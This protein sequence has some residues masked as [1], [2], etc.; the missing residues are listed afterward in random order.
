M[1]LLF[2]KR[3][4]ANP[5]RVGY[6]VP[7]SPALTRKVAKRIDFT[8]PRVVVELGPGE[9]CHTRQIVKRMNPESKLLLFEL[10]PEFAGHLR[11]QFAHDPRVTVLHT[12]AIHLPQTLRELG[13]ERCD[14]IVSGLPF[15]VIES[16]IKDKLL[17]SIAQSMDSESRFITYQVTTQLCDQDH[18]FE[19]AGREY[20]ALN[21]PPIN[22]LEF[23][24][25][26]K[27]S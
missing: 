4:L 6:V 22:V 15:L 9:G 20:C 18:L 10:D 11:K 24:R 13:H 8:R 16:T 14:Y 26:E 25:S 1:S 21:L 17:Q 12:D 19:L 5:L 2:F 23:R 3:V 27:K 7:S